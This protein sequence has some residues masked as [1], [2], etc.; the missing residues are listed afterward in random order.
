MKWVK[1]IAATTLVASL[2]A[3][4]GFAAHAAETAPAATKDGFKLTI[5]HSNDTHAHVEAAPQ[6]ATKVQE[7]R[8]ANANT[9]LLDAGD[10]FSGTLYFNQFS[11]EVDMKLM[12]LM[13]YDAMTFGNHEFDLGSSPEGHAALAK[14]VKGADF[15]IL[16]ANLDF[17]KDSLFDGLQF[18]TVTKD[19]EKVKFITVLLKKSMEKK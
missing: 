7:L 3:T 16:S 18:K 14:F 11:G 17:S 8:A 5:L 12:N 9:L 1:S 10:V 15:P 2:L 4:P 19:F 13:G 6:R